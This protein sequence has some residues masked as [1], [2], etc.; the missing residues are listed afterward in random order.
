MKASPIC[1][2][3]V[4][5]MHSSNA[6]RTR[7]AALQRT[8][9]LVAT[10]EGIGIH[11]GKDCQIW[12]RPASAGT[13]IV[14]APRG[15]TDQTVSASLDNVDGSQNAV[16]LRHGDYSV[17]TVE[18]L[19]SALYGL[20]IDNAIVETQGPEVPIGDGSSAVFV[21]AISRARPITQNTPRRHLEI[22]EP[23]SVEDGNRKISADVSGGDSGDVDQ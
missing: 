18:H 14:F 15:K 11:S 20:E 22:L 4:T 3:F 10:V 2:D 5:Y 6:P 7:F 1:Y 23:L 19:I 13:G 17:S 8:V 21:D 16:Q 9:S 12:I